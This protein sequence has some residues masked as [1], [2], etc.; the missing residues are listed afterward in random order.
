VKKFNFPRIIKR[1]LFTI[2][3]GDVGKRRFIQDYYN[4][5]KRSKARF[6]MQKIRRSRQGWRNKVHGSIWALKVRR[7]FGRRPVV[8]QFRR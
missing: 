6:N 3:F 8:P 1:K 7:T 2:I 4:K 5:S